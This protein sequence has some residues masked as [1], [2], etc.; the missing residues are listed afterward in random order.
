MIDPS[1][2]NCTGGDNAVAK[3][4]IIAVQMAQDTYEAK[5][6]QQADSCDATNCSPKSSGRLGRGQSGRNLFYSKSEKGFYGADHFATD[7]P[8]PAQTISMAGMGPLPSRSPGL[9]PAAISCCR[10]FVFQIHHCHLPL[11][12][13]AKQFPPVV[14]GGKC[15]PV[16]SRC[17]VCHPDIT[18]RAVLRS[19][20]LSSDCTKARV[21]KHR[22]IVPHLNQPHGE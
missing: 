10:L 20:G 9:P 5:I 18:T 17:A 13:T 3:A 4:K 22:K 14:I 16:A 19:S 7:I 1:G 21:R 11:S 8:E 2:L 15:A 12:P 6:E